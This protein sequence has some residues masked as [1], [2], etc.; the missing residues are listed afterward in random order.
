MSNERGD[1][2]QIEASLAHWEERALVA[3]SSGE[4]QKALEAHGQALVLAAQL[5]RPRLLAA[6]Y[7]RLG[8]ALEAANQVQQAV[9]AYESGLRALTGESGLGA[10]SGLGPADEEIEAVLRA[11]GSAAKGFDPSRSLVDVP[12]LYSQTTA[13]DLGQAEADRALPVK[14]LINVGNAYLRQPQLGP[15]LA[16]YGQ[17]L[18]RPEIEAA[19]LLR[20]HTLTHIGLIRRQQGSPDD[21]EAALQHAL[22]LFDQ[23]EALGGDVA[24]KR[25]ALAALAGIHRDRG[26]FDDALGAY[27][28]A[29]SLYEASDDILGHGRAQAGLGHLYLQRHRYG[30]AQTAFARAVELAQR[31]AD[32]ETLWHAHWGLGRCQHAA[33][34]LDA[35]ADSLQHALTKIKARRRQLRTDEGKVTFLQSVQQVFDQ[36]IEVHLDR[37]ATDPVAYWAVLAVIE[38][39]RGQ[40]LY[41]LMGM[42]R[43]QFASQQVGY[44]E[45]R[46]RSLGEPRNSPQQMAPG[47]PSGGGLSNMVTQMAPGTPSGPGLS[48][49]VAQMAPGVESVASPNL[50]QLLDT[51]LWDEDLDPLVGFVE[52]A[53]A[54]ANEALGRPEETGSPAPPSSPALRPLARLVFHTLP[55]RTVVLAIV[56]D[57]SDDN[58]GPRGKIQGHVAAVG[59]DELAQRVAALRQAL[60]VDD[61]PRGVRPLRDARRRQP[62]AAAGDPEPLLRALHAD[63]VEPLADTLPADGTP[64]VVEPHG[65][66]WLLPFAALQAAD[67]SWLADRCPLL[68]SPSGNV[69]D[70]IRR[71]PDYGAPGEL[72]TL[73]VG[74]PAMPTLVRQGDLEV[75]LAPLPGAEAEARA[76]AGIFPSA[77]TTLLLGDAADWASVVAQ[78][79]LHGIVHLSTHGLANADKPLDS[80]I[81]LGPPGEGTLKTLAQH[82]Q[83]TTGWSQYHFLRQFLEDQG[84]RGLLTAEQILYLPL[85]ADLVTLSACQT[86]LGQISGDGMIGLA[87]SFLVAGARAVL[88]SQW[89]VSDTATAEL[90]LSFYRYYVDFDDKALALQ[91]AMQDLRA[92]PQYDHPR[93]WA[94]FVIVGAEA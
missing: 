1:Q 85:P 84:H 78:M 64:V 71:E 92:M 18:M 20:A 34:E 2:A 7:N 62:E 13:S 93:Y 26:R 25:R 38:E 31:A 83:Q 32:E 66:L 69:L 90:M 53:P 60:Q 11:L 58:A 14:L 82:R 5:G 40:A 86:G 8:N 70:E 39:A 52:A 19:P 65:P 77:R 12:D 3:T 88:V 89:S 22:E 56:P 41:D 48:S 21:A 33:G 27:Q 59:H 6:L 17:A 51:P 16:A 43:R 73:V 9:I 63:L 46:L 45:T 87:R 47:I 44:R 49:M 30:E 29:L 67:G 24:E 81:V 75:E 23:Q 50:G 15:A 54:G 72:S 36:L 79:P 55:R 91:R 10:G 42:R 68:H 76:I 80:F 37:T 74:N 28:E 4:H 61:A 94:P 35:A 57:S